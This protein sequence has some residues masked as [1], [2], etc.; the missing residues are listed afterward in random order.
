M[1]LK[2]YM[3]TYKGHTRLNPTLTSLF[4]SDLID[5][6]YELNIINNGSNGFTVV[7]VVTEPTTSNAPLGCDVP[8]VTI[9][10]SG[11]PS[12]SLLS[13]PSSQTSAGAC[14][15]VIFLFFYSNWVSA[16]IG[17]AFIILRVLLV[18]V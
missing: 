7:L 5:H 15:T 1:K 9:K 11:G 13:L 12:T 18:V 16:P 10:V 3:V 4:N 14:S 6:N 2:I 17:R 8:K